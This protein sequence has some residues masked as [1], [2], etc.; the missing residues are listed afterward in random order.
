[1]GE[2][3]CDDT[4]VVT[5]IIDLGIIQARSFLVN[6]DPNIDYRQVMDEKKLYD[7]IN[8]KFGKMKI[9]FDYALQITN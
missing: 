3:I 4:E 5:C 9:F 7:I 6:E 8:V 2:K 1:M